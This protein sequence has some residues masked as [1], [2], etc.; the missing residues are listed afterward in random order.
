[1]EFLGEKSLS[2]DKNISSIRQFI[3]YITFQALNICKTQIRKWRKPA[4]SFEV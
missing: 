1:M 4:K 3:A 2:Q